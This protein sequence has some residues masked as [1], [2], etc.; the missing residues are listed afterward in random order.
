MRA[1]IMVAAGDF[2]EK[3]F[4]ALLKIEP[5][6]FIM[7]IDGGYAY[8]RARGV[9]PDLALGDFDSLGYVPGDV[10][11]QLHPV[12]K[13]K[14]DMILAIDKALELGFDSAFVLGAFGGERFDHS[15]SNLQSLYYAAEKL[16]LFYL[17]DKSVCFSLHGE[18]LKIGES[19]LKI[20]SAG[21]EETQNLPDELLEKMRVSS[22]YFSIFARN[23][24][25]VD[26][27]GCSYSGKG[28]EITDAFPLG[29]SNEI[30]ANPAEISV[31][32]DVIII[33]SGKH[34]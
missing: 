31:Q 2:S 34:N 26:I 12:R 4:E 27:S 13:D 30:Q 22:G 24:A 8:L 10:E 32:G 25:C 18:S 29:A 23:K 21:G 5:R 3:Y 9:K 11:I 16:H 28:F 33:L 19:T 15:I 17:D 1:C 6:P 7:A 14:T 20:L